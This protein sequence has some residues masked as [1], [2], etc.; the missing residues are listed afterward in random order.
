MGK[1]PGRVPE[2]PEI[3]SSEDGEP[4]KPKA[5]MVNL[6]TSASNNNNNNSSSGSADLLGLGLAGGNGGSEEA[7]Q[8][9]VNGNGFSQEAP[10]NNLSKFYCKNNGVLYENDT[11]QIGIKTECRDTVT[12]I[13]F[14]ADFSSQE[15][16]FDRRG[17]GSVPT[18]GQY[19]MSGGFYSAA[20]PKCQ[21]H[22]QRTTSQNPT[23]DTH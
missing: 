16:G 4:A 8:P 7:S 19:R 23:Q 18:N 9:S 5:S 20:R 14:L 11:I 2:N 17:R 10:T 12:R 6:E 21:F 3:K 1:R 13:D 15:R 22:L